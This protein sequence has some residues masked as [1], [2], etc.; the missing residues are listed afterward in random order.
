[1]EFSTTWGLWRS[2]SRFDIL[3]CVASCNCAAFEH[4]LKPLPLTISLSLSPSVPHSFNPVISTLAVQFRMAAFRKDAECVRGNIRPSSGTQVCW[5]TSVKFAHYSCNGALLYFPL[6][7]VMC[8][9]ALARPSQ[10]I[11]KGRGRQ[12]DRHRRHPMN[13]QPRRRRLATKA[14]RPKKSTL[15]WTSR[16]WWGKLPTHASH[17]SWRFLSAIGPV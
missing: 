12:K 14:A 13:S 5:G 1:M 7:R 8:A 15:R 4:S 16:L 17:V 2:M 10:G 3:L 9:T 11:A 6:A